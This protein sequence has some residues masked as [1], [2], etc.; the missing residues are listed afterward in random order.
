MLARQDL[1][2]SVSLR[3]LNRVGVHERSLGVDVLD[4]F[5]PQLRPVAKVEGADVAL[6]ERG[7]KRK[8]VEEERGARLEQGTFVRSV[9]EEGKK[10]TDQLMKVHI[11]Y[12]LTE[13]Y[14]EIK[15]FK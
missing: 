4:F 9:T 2:L 10:S 14:P 8:D 3:G 5:G 7:R 6:W 12:I 11:Y 1:L 13:I 15:C